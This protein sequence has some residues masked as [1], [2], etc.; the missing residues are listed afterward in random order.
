TIGPQVLPSECSIQLVEAEAAALVPTASDCVPCA[1]SARRAR[2]E[3]MPSRASSEKLVTLQ[4]SACTPKTS[5]NNSAAPRASRRIAPAPSNWTRG[6][7]AAASA[8][9]ADDAVDSGGADAGK[10]SAAA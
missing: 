8:S 4:T 3:L 6:A 1:S 5:F 7:S 2:S 9:D 10:E